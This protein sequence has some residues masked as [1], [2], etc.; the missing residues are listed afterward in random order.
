MVQEW[1]SYGL[2]RG[3]RKASILYRSRLY[4]GASNRIRTGDLILT[5]AETYLLLRPAYSLLVPPNPLDS[6]GFAALLE[7]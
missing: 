3:K 4:G 5:N 7:L 1:V 6:Q 2:A